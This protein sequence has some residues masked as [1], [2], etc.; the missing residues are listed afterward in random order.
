MDQALLD[1]F[2]AE[3]GLPGPFRVEVGLKGDPTT[4]VHEFRQ[5]F[6]VIGRRGGSDMLLDHWQVSRRHAY[7][8]LIEGR[9]YGVDLGSR[10]G[11]HG[12]DATERAGWLEPG[13]AIQIG[14][15]LV[16]PALPTTRERDYPPLPIVT[17]TIT[18]P[19]EDRSFWSMNRG[20]ALVGR[21]PAC[22]VRLADPEVSR[23][24]CSLVLTTSGVWAVDLLSQ[25][26]LLVNGR[27]VRFA[28]VDPGD[29]LQI[30]RHL[31][32]PEYD[33][34]LIQ[35]A[36]TRL[37]APPGFGMPLGGLGDAA[38]TR[39]SSSDMLPAL[40]PTVLPP[41]SRW[42]TPA[43]PAMGMAVPGDPALNSIVQ[44]FG[45]MQQ[46]MFD[47]FHQTMLM[48]FEGFAALHRET[49]G[50][51][52][53]EFDEVRKLSQEIE[54]LREE[55]SK[56]AEVATLSLQQ[57]AFQKADLRRKSAPLDEPTDVLLDKSRTVP[58]PRMTP[59][60]PDPHVDIH[61][62]LFERLNHI[63]TERQSRWQ[64]ILGMMAGGT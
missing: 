49:S 43:V 9:F 25:R 20:L 26:S 51:I 21:S 56:L 19:T 5:P 58:P 40:N 6:L 64:K 61:A 48:M 3:C 15:Y 57:P 36:A 22:R 16:R 54:S 60:P 33:L 63:Q 47:Q 32:V 7:L 1:E 52:R 17:W 45:A 50:S 18:S 62:Q 8:Q 34:S 31:L 13:R 2:L 39:P 41:G 59:P 28:R 14:P 35:A 44:Q 23:F 46:Q 55:T 11:T 29:E 4:Q 27:A 30:G 10:T 12:G 37:V 42:Q 24:H 53:Q 38:G